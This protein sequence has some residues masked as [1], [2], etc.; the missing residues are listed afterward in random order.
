MFAS[1]VH[2]LR[3]AAGLMRGERMPVE[4]LARIA[5]DLV[6]TVRE[7]GEPGEDSALL[8]GQQGPIDPDVRRT[9]LTRALRRTAR[10]AATRTA[11]YQAMFAGLG[12]R[13]HDLT[14]DSWTELPVTPKA[15]L[16]GMPAAFVASGV[17]PALLALTTGTSG[18]PT[19]VWLSRREVDM[20]VALN[21]ISAVLG[22]RLRP[23][24]VVAYAGSS[25]GTIPVLC[26]SAAVMAV[27]ATFVQLG[28]LAPE[29]ALERLAAPLPLPGPARQITH[30]TANTSYLAALV[31]AAER[32]GWRPADFGLVSLQ[33]GGEV[34]SDALRLRARRAFGVEPET[35]YVL[36]EGM[37]A[38]A[39][40]CSARHLHHSAEFAHVEVLDPVTYRPVAPGETGTVVLTPLLPYRECTL[41]LRYVTG[42]LVRTLAA[43]PTC[44]LAAIPATS[45]ILGRYGGPVSLEVP[46]RQVLEIL[47]AEPDV[48]LPARY[49]LVEE[50]GGPVLHVLARHRSPR[51]LARLEDA[52]AL[53]LPLGG[54]ILH[55]DPATMPPTPPLR[56]DL[57][58]HSFDHHPTPTV[59][60]RTTPAA[61]PAHP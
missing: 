37:P 11:Y 10:R 56:A 26:V 35:G 53:A 9:V 45:D 3:Y 49:A 59:F 8:P 14:L 22:Q 12:V 57:R 30:L 27:G 58:E 1:A 5:R 16:R 17:D 60:P 41:L 50:P 23:G 51:L 21:T 29:V 24:H 48:A 15:A 25:R 4:S 36:T 47:D 20:M 55:E 61:V 33:A 54:I 18:T 44:E 32:G 46:H 52:A 6:A 39:R 38:G 2:Q 7:F 28:T 31:S 40:L 34:L 19:H 42:D 43:P 13:P